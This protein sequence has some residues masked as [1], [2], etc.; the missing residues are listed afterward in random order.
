[1]IKWTRSI[2]ARDGKFHEALDWAKEIAEHVNSLGPAHPV[3]VYV[4]KFGDLNSIIWAW[5]FEDLAAMEAF[6]KKYEADEG[7]QERLKQSSEL[8]TASTYDQV[9]VLAE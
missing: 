8:F 1:M 5:D 3:Q 2:K 9:Y 7:F 6:Q 4:P